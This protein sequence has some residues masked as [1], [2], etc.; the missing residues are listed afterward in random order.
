MDLICD[1]GHAVTSVTSL[2][3][4]YSNVTQNVLVPAFCTS[5][6]ADTHEALVFNLAK[7]YSQSVSAKVSIY[8][9]A[10]GA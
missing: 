1:I 10:G 4:G 2:I 7:P 5:T 6:I 9:R 3:G 8:V